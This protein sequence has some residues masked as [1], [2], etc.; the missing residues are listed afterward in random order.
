MTKKRTRHAKCHPPRPGTPHRFPGT[1]AMNLRTLILLV[2]WRARRPHR[3]SY[4]GGLLLGIFLYSR[5]L[6]QRGKCPW[7]L[8]QQTCCGTHGFHRAPPLPQSC[9]SAGREGLPRL[10]PVSPPGIPPPTAWP[11]QLHS[12]GPTRKPRAGQEWTCVGHTLTGRPQ[13]LCLSS[14]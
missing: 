2:S 4:S 3:N 12:S 5:Y 14:S 11:S 10:H 13:V 8:S 1:W 9:S 6:S 7:L